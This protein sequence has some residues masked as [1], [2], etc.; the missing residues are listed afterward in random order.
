MKKLIETQKNDGE[1]SNKT[2]IVLLYLKTLF[3]KKDKG[4]DIY[5][6]SKRVD[7]YF[8]EIKVKD[9]KVNEI[10]FFE[11]MCVSAFTCQKQNKKVLNENDIESICNMLN[12]ESIDRIL[13]IALEEHIMIKNGSVY[14]FSHPIL[15]EIMAALYIH[16]S[17]GKTIILMI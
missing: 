2:D 15:Q 11:I 8:G 10:S 4:I 5:G 6:V 14:V 12:V 9:I 16:A 3:D 13:A 1:I 7:S 17:W